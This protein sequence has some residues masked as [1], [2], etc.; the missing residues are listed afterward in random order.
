[1]IAQDV[2]RGDVVF[3]PEG[4]EVRIVE[5]WSAGLGSWKSFIGESLG[6]TRHTFEAHMSTVIAY[7][8]INYRRVSIDGESPCTLQELFEASPSLADTDR[9]AL[10]RLLVGERCTVGG[11]AGAEFQIRRVA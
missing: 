5:A 2:T 3:T 1:M 9:V 8:P 11:G 10:E 7:D 6:G 4:V